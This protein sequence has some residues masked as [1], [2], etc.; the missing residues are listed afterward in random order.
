[1]NKDLLLLSYLRQNSRMSLT[2]LSK[3][4]GIPISTIFDKI[5][6]THGSLI[7]RHVCLIDFSKLGFSVNVT[8][9]LK[10]GKNQRKEAG[11]Y[12]KK[13]FNINSLLKI[14]NGYDYLLDGVFHNLKELEQFFDVLETKFT[15]KKKDVYYTI[16]DIKREE[17]LADPSVLDY[18]MEEAT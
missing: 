7:Q 13:F 10:V 1:M 2:K 16:E 8:I 3:K 6:K 4:T 15:L 5:R 12:L 11:E 9:L 18:V 14:N 17:F